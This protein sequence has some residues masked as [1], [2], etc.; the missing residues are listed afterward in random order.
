M[1]TVTYRP[2]KHELKIKGHAGFAEHGNDVI[3]AAV[4]MVFYNL[5]QMLLEYD[6][7]AFVGKVDMQNISGSACVKVTPASGYESWID[8]DFLYALTGFRM[9]MAQFPD[10]VNLKVMKK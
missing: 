9:L 2:T 6:K 1:I 5:C 8:H 10:Y 3:C 4:S 7:K